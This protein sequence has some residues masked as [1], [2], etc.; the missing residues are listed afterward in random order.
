MTEEYI[1]DICEEIKTKELHIESEKYYK[2]PWSIEHSILS[3]MTDS[4]IAIIIADK[5]SEWGIL[6][7]EKKEAM[8][9]LRWENRQIV[10]LLFLDEQELINKLIKK[11]QYILKSRSWEDTWKFNSEDLQRA[12]ETI[13]II[14][15][16][17]VITWIKASWYKLMKCPFPAHKDKTPSMKIYKNTNSFFCQW[18]RKWW[19]CID[20]IMNMNQCSLPEAINQFMQFYKK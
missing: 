17:E 3:M 20:F 13:S 4:D 9:W 2:T 14:D 12:K 8:K 15:L 11:F 18:C 5:R 19:S 16:I 1:A 10:E 6:E 7:K